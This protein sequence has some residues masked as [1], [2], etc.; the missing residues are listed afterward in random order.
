M[1]ATEAIIRANEKGE[2]LGPAGAKM[3]SALSKATEREL[4]IVQRKGAFEPGTPLTPPETVTGKNVGVRATGPL[5]RLRRMQELQG[6][7]SVTQMAGAL[8]QYGPEV[9]GDILD[10]IDHDETLELVREIRG[11]PRKMFRTDEEVAQR[12]Q[13][14]EQQAA[15]QA[16]LMATES[17]AKAAGQATPA[18]QAAMQANAA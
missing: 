16:G 13:A 3:E 6:V 7:E 15:N 14:R 10:R 12:R 11:A 4:D 9:A 18:I 17:L 2:L 8:A 1:T 5:S